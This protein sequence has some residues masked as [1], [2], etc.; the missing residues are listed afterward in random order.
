MAYVYGVAAVAKNTW[1]RENIFLND[2][3]CDVKQW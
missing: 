3:V 2:I 1:R